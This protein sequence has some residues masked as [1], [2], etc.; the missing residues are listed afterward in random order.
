V[1]SV[2][3]LAERV[4]FEMSRELGGD[5]RSLERVNIAHLGIYKAAQ[6]YDSDRG[7]FPPWAKYLAT[8]EILMVERGER[9]QK[10]ML[11]AGRVAGFRWLAE[12]RHRA[13][14]IPADASDE[15]L[16]EALTDLARE[17]LVAELLGELVAS[18]EPVEGGD[19]VAERDAW[20]HAMASFIRALDSLQPQHREML[21][22]FAHGHNIKAIAAER[23]VD[24]GTLLERFHEQLAL[25]RARM[26]AM[27]V[28]HAQ[29][30]PRDALA[31]LPDPDDDPP[32]GA[33]R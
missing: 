16:T 5:P 25:V 13:D 3:G 7:P 19:D 17:E 23:D 11:T 6:S 32:S 29:R 28:R 12:R 2:P 22:R 15:E 20:A 9:K 4:T 10:R 30:A 21:V 31:V 1:R 27:N 24:Y 8:C 18:E 33:R 26:E 14:D